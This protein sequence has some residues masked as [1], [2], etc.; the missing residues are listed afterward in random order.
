[1]RPLS[2]LE[3]QLIR[4]VYQAWMFHGV[5]ADLQAGTPVDLSWQVAHLRKRSALVR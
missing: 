5:R 2:D 4:P 3:W 1:V